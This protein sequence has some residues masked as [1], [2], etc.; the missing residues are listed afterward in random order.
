MRRLKSLESG[1]ADGHSR[2]AGGGGVAWSGAL[3]RRHAPDPPSASLNSLKAFVSHCPVCGDDLTHSV[4]SRISSCK[5]VEEGAPGG[6]GSLTTVT[7]LASA[8]AV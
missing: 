4:A 3:H 2:Q 5:E 8:V 7:P 1:W 6:R